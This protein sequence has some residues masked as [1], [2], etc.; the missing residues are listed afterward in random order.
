VNTLNELKKFLEYSKPY[1]KYYFFVFISMAFTTVLALPI[2]LVMRHIID[3]AIPNKDFKILHLLVMAIFTTYLVRACLIYFQNYIYGHIGNSIC[4]DIRKKVL[5]KVQ[6]LPL[7]YLQKK[8]AGETVSLI[9]NDVGNLKE[10]FTNAFISLFSNTLTVIV[11]LGLLITFNWKLTL[12]NVLIIPLYWIITHKSN[13]KLR[14]N[15]IIT[16]QQSSRIMAGV[17]ENILN[18]KIIRAFN[19]EGVFLK[20]VIDELKKLININ[21]KGIKLNSIVSQLNFIIISAGPLFVLWFGSGLTIKGYMSVGS[22]I[23]Y[24]QYLSQ[25]YTPIGSYAG[26]NQKFQT[27]WGSMSRISDFLNLTANEYDEGNIVENVSGNIE[28]KS[29]SFKYSNSEKLVLN[30]INLMIKEGEFIG[31]VGDSGAGKTTIANVLMRFFLLCSGE[32]YIDGHN[33]T[34]IK[35]ESLYNCI[36]LVTQDA[37]MFNTTIDENIRL[38]RYDATFEDVRKAAKMAQIDDLIMSLPDKYNTIVEER[39]MNF[40]GGERQRISLARVFLKDPKIIILDEASSALDSRTEKLIHDALETNYSRVTRIVIA[41][42]LSTLV[43]ADR[44]IVLID[45]VIREEGSHEELINNKGI[46]YD[47]YLKQTKSNNGVHN[48]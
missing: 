38:G 46:Y 32:I 4:L 40:S 47:L 1:K 37:Y 22:L 9:M 11:I 36:G 24:Y 7:D 17:F 18:Q 14:D 2:P 35:T 27:A 34:D 12:V 33:I 39:G 21:I 3:Y 16:Q 19:I 10:I 45:G 25:I 23:A 6:K 30:N 13:Y 26:I 5:M 8:P 48:V 29:A 15:S 28:F 44:I 20:K 31:I 42:R 43:N 41:H